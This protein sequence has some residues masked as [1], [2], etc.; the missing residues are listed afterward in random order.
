VNR[1]AVVEEEEEEE[2]EEGLLATR[3]LVDHDDYVLYSCIR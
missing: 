1:A 2:E 3:L